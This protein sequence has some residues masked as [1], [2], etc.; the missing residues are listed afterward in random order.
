MG[1][2]KSAHKFQSGEC[3]VF[4]LT[5]EIQELR[6]EN[7][8]GAARIPKAEDRQKFYAEKA[9]GTGAF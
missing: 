7:P 6:D 1:R 5:K 2:F 8:K 9:S 4:V 3:G